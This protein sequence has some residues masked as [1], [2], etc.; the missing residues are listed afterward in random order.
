ME[1]G[2]KS[3]RGFQGMTGG[4]RGPQQRAHLHLILSEVND[5]QS[6][7]DDLPVTLVIDRGDFGTLAL[8][9]GQRGVTGLQPWAPRVAPALPAATHLHQVQVALGVALQAQPEQRLLLTPLQQLVEDVEVPLPV[10]LVHHSGLLQ[11]VTE[12][13]AA[14][15]GPLWAGKDVAA[16]QGGWEVGPSWPPSPALLGS[17]SSSAASGAGSGK[18]PALA[19]VSAPK[20]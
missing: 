3:G 15:G 14:H 16:A 11:E 12:D 1:L 19:S 7:P 2:C 17:N 4:K 5:H 13:V 8:E 18:P 6:L 10:V 20:Q 9:E